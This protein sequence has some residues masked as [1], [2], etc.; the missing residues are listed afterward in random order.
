M[1][2]LTHEQP[3]PAEDKDHGRDVLLQQSGSKAPCNDALTK[4]I[5]AINEAVCRELWHVVSPGQR[6]EAL[7]PKLIFPELRKG[8][9]RV[10]EQE[11]RFIYCSVLNRCSGYFYSVETPTEESYS[12]SGLNPMSARSDISLYSC[13]DGTVKDK[14]VNI[15]LKAGN[16]SAKHIEKDVEKLVKE[17]QVGNWFHCLSNIDSRTLRVLFKK[18]ELSFQSVVSP[19]TITP[20]IVFCFCVLEKNW[21]IVNCFDPLRESVNQFFDLEY[22]VVRGSVNVTRDNGWRCIRGL[23]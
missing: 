12:F 10:S 5:L 6:V 3:S 9:V 18:L 22:A 13:E 23:K 17:R 14:V 19:A 16:C 8:G 15:E 2:T 21:A 7:T 4:D 20:L 1:V 11:A